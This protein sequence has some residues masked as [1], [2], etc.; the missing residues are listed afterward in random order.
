MTALVF[1]T[2][3]KWVLSQVGAVTLASRRGLD[4]A[5]TWFIYRDD[6]PDYDHLDYVKVEMHT[7]EGFRSVDVTKARLDEHRHAGL[8]WTRYPIEMA[9]GWAIK[10]ALA[11]VFG[12]P[13]ESADGSEWTAIIDAIV[14]DL[15]QGEPR[16]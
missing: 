8:A 13:L 14:E 1:R 9:K 16:T 3:T 2:P 6:V 12:F 11:E 7:S 4:S 5:R 15:D 10:L